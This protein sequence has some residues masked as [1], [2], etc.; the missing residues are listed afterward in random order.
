MDATAP[1]SPVRLFQ[2]SSGT[3]F[4]DAYVGQVGWEGSE[5]SAA[6]RL[7][8]Y[9][10]RQ[11]FEITGPFASKTGRQAQ[12]WMSAFF[13]SGPGVTAAVRDFWQN[14]PKAV[15]T[16]TNGTISV[17]LFPEGSRFNHNLRVGE[18]KTHS[19]LYRFGA[20]PISADEAGRLSMA[21]NN[22]LFGVASP[23]WCVDSGALGETPA[24][25]VY[26]WPLYERYVRVAFEP[27]PDV[28]PNDD[29]AGFGNTTL[30]D[31]IEMYNFYGW[32][33]Y[34]DVPLDYESFGPSQA[35]QMNLKYWF[36]HGMF[37]QFLRSGD[38][39]WLDLALPAARHLSDIDYLHIPDNGIQH[40]AH[41]AYFG[42]SEHGEPGCIDPNRNVNSPS[43]DLLFGVPDLIL[44]YHVTGERRFLDVAL[45]G[46]EGMVNL[47]QFD[48]FTFPVFYR[49]RANLIFAYMEGYRQTGDAGWLNQMRSIVQPIADL[50]NKGWL[51]DPAS[52]VP[53][54]YGPEGDERIS[55]FQFA[56]VLW[57][58]GRYLDF[59]DEY[60]LED[61][62]GVAAAL[63]AYGNFIIDHLM[64]EITEKP[65]YYATISSIW[66]TADN[67]TYQEVNNWALLMADVLA[68]AYKYSGK[69]EF[70]DAAAKLY[71]TG[72]IDQAWL[73]DAPVYIATKDLVNSCNWGLTYM[74]TLASSGCLSLTDDLG[75][76]IPCFDLGGD[77]FGV[78][79]DHSHGL[80][81]EADAGS[82]SPAGGDECLTLGDGYDIQVPCFDLDGKRFEFT[83]II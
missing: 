58:L 16:S 45:E 48:D 8:S 37:L 50:S 40:W 25:N 74:N 1:S 44:G 33:D 55:G 14:F 66:F 20:N 10:V 57:T 43:T 19:I 39:E 51:T 49:R 77:R 36:V 27:N 42:H 80:V 30:L 18:E 60:L 67:E 26:R 47:S 75:V 54:P 79:F 76:S 71:Q 11:D 70:L 82:L 59:C 68:Y 52:Y 21:F 6:P 34:G 72:T 64:R 32:Q 12:G 62:L 53:P 4:W 7:Q 78:T 46:L 35:G 5:A 2:D 15:E 69:T 3:D 17:D 13:P 81:W 31:A 65:G 83:F 23:S 38:H 29:A 28:G 61:D 9:C 41:G 73:D 63:E 24:K 22:P 56:Q